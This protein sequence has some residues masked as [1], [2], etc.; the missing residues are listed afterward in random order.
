MEKPLQRSPLPKG[1][2][3]EGS[4]DWPGDIDL[5]NAIPDLIAGDTNNA[6]Y[7]QFDF[8]PYSENISFRIIN[9]LGQTVIKGTLTSNRIDV[10]S[11]KKG[12][13]MKSFTEWNIDDKRMHQ[14]YVGAEAYIIKNGKTCLMI[15]FF[16]FSKL[17]SIS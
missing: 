5:E 3:G 13:Y 6:T 2:I 1:T 7:I 12:I 9:T 10:N 17:F 16:S 11:L 14:R 8:T 15:S 4:F